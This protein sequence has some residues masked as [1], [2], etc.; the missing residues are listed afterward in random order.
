MRMLRRRDCLG[1][2]F[3][4][5]FFSKKR[6]IAEPLHSRL[7]R[8]QQSRRRMH[9]FALASLPQKACIINVLCSLNGTQHG[10]RTPNE[11]KSKKSEN[12]GQCGR[13]KMLWPYL[14]IREWELIFCRAVKI[15]FLTGRPQSVVQSVALVTAASL[16]TQLAQLDPERS[17]DIF[18]F[19]F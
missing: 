14:K 12:L 6:E 19:Q 17:I 9:N 8:S 10:L 7:E 11:D 18:F 4:S 16:G 2:R 1:D 13:R 3:Q 5:V 15:D